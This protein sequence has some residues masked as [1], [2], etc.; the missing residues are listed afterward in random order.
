MY[1]VLFSFIIALSFLCKANAEDYFSHSII[2][3]PYEYEVEEPWVMI[4]DSDD[5]LEAFYKKTIKKYLDFGYEVKPMPEI[6]FNQYTLVVGGLGFQSTGA[7]HL[8]IGRIIELSDTIYINAVKIVLGRG[9]A[10]TADVVYPT[11][12]ILLKKTNKKIVAYLEKAVS[13]C[14]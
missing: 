5:D 14:E 11:T 2:N 10:G 7:N 9:C 12:G 3:L 1:K 4:L 8:A 13:D 6:D